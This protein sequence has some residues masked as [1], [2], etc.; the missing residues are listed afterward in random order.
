MPDVGGGEEHV[1]DVEIQQG[2][3]GEGHGEEDDEEGAGQREDMSYTVGHAPQQHAICPCTCI[4]MCSCIGHT[5]TIPMI[6]LSHTVVDPWT[7]M[8]HTQHTSR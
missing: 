3:C 1:G 7:V 8:I 2:E 4:Y 5:W 6:L